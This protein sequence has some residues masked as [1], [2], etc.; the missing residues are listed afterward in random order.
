TYELGTKMSLLGGHLRFDTAVFDSEY[1]DYQ[2]SGFSL[3]LDRFTVANAGNA[4]IKGI[5]TDITWRATDQWSLSLNGNYLN[6][7]FTRIDLLN[8]AAN[9]GD[10]I[11]NVPKY[12]F[13]VA[14]QRDF[15]LGDKP[16]FVRVGY[17][18]QGRET[19]RNRAAGPWFY[20]ESDIIHLL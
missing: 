5:E 18:E 8:T 6:A 7:R 3:A 17:A 2:A 15:R 13:T 1:T 12:Q 11:D 9:V 19:F 14:A 4:R 16:G 10:S 20:G